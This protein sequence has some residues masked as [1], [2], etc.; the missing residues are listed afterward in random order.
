MLPL[1]LTGKGKY[2]TM[3]AEIKAQDRLLTAVGCEE[4][5]KNVKY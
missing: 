3:Q 2:L 5:R 4:L 1:P